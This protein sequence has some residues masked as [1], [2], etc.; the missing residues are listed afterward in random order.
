MPHCSVTAHRPSDRA[1]LR[2]PRMLKKQADKPLE[3]L[4]HRRREQQCYAH[5]R[6]HRCGAAPDGTSTASGSADS[7][8]KPGKRRILA[9][10][11]IH[12]SLPITPRL[13]HLPDLPAEWYRTCIASAPHGAMPTTVPPQVRSASPTKT[14]RRTA[15][16]QSRVH[17][18]ES[19]SPT[20]LPCASPTHIARLSSNETSIPA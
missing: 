3:K 10:R 14:N 16:R 20:I 13:P 5:L 11:S 15:G 19:S 12:A 7:L 9:V 17:A 1:A 6:A 4:H 8:T 2:R 18:R